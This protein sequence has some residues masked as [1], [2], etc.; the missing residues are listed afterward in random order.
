VTGRTIPI[1]R[2]LVNRPADIRLY[3]TD[4][5]KVTQMTGWEPRIGVEQI[6]QEITDWIRANESALA[7]IL[8]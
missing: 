2:E 3:L 4:N 7:P 8:S 5:A 6:V 1:R